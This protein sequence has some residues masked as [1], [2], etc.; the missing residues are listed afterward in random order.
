M[1]VRD[2]EEYTSPIEKLYKMDNAYVVVTANSI[3]LVNTNIQVKQVNL[4]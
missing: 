4:S 2:E 1:I 3:Y